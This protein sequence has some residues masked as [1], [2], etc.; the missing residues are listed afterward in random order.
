LFELL[1]VLICVLKALFSYLFSYNAGEAWKA[2]EFLDRFMN[3]LM[4][5]ILPASCCKKGWLHSSCSSSITPWL[6]RG[7][8]RPYRCWRE[9]GYFKIRKLKRRKKRFYL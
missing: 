6:W 5:S 4:Y 7:T 9:Q 3:T 2:T 1:S 8:M